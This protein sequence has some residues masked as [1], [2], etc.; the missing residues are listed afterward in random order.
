MLRIL[1]LIAVGFLVYQLFKRSKPIRTFRRDSHGQ[2]IET[3]ELV[4]DP[5][6]RTF[7]ARDR[8]LMYHG[9]YFCSSKCRDAFREVQGSD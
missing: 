9:T 3:K 8:A 2:E 6:C 1:I 7:V 5:V 4:R